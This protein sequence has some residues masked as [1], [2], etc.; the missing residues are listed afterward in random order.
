LWAASADLRNEELTG[1]REFH[2]LHGARN[3][4]VGKGLAVSFFSSSLSSFPPPP[5]RN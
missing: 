1:S 5:Y 4:F 2:A 3:H